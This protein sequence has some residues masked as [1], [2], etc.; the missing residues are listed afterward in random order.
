[1]RIVAGRHRGRRLVA[2]PGHDTRPTSDRVRE[3]LFNLLAHSIDW[4]GLPLACA[5]L[6]VRDVD[7]L[8]QR[9]LIIK[10]HDP[11]RNQEDGTRNPVD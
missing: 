5:W 10:T 8:L 4:A 1:M 11:K 9:L 3:A 7:G 2:P 6:G